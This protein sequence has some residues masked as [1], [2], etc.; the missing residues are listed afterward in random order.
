MNDYQD[1]NNFNYSGIDEL[2]K[3]EWFLVNYNRN[4]VEMLSSLSTHDD[5][6]LEFGAG[7]G[8]LALVWSNLKKTQPDCVEIDPDLRNIIREKG[9]N[10]FDDLSQIN[11]KY[12]FVYSSNVLEHILD[13]LDALHKLNKIINNDGHLAIYVPAFNFLYNKVDA[14]VGHYRRYEKFELIEKIKIAGFSIKE[15]R[16]VDSIG[17]F[18][19]LSLRIKKI[20]PSQK[21]SSGMSLK[22]YDSYIYPVSKFLDW[23]GLKHFF[24]KNILVVAQKI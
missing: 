15:C 18:A 9:L 17:F 20:E 5:R 19:W 13:D 11:E 10:C 7:L 1:N 3:N 8:T 2:I 16:Y 21:I 4:I 22:I 24:G 14:S 12:D 23:L 6:V